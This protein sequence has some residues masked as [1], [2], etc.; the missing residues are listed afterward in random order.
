[1][2]R[3]II[4][5]LI[6]ITV[7]SL[8][9][10]AQIAQCGRFVFNIPDVYEDD[11]NGLFYNIDKGSI[12]LEELQIT[13]ELKT[14]DDYKEFLESYAKPFLSSCYNYSISYN[15]KMIYIVSACVIHAMTKSFAEL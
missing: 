4:L 2:K 7:C 1:M 5:S 14:E 11:G 6:I 10:N 3:I 15:L 9:V 12:G 13:S 8:P